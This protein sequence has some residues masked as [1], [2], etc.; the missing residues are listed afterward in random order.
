MSSTRLRRLL[1]V[2]FALLALLL[3]GGVGYGLSHTGSNIAASVPAAGQAAPDFAGI[4]DWENSPPLT[5][6]GLRGKVVLVDFWTY[7]CINCQRTFPYLRDWWHK[8]RDQGLVIVGVH[9]PEF[10]FEKNVPNIRAAIR[11]YGVEWPVAV[12]SA[13]T[14]WNAYQNQYWP[15][16]YLVDK[17]GNVR[18]R[19]EAAIRQRLADAGHP[20]DGVP[21]SRIDPGLTV[22]AQLQSHELY[23]AAGRGFSANPEHPGQA[24]AYTDPGADG[25][26]G[27]RRNNFIYWQG[28]WTIGQEFAEY[29]GASPPAPGYFAIE[30]QARNVYMVAASASGSRRAYVTLDGV[31]VARADAGAAIQYDGQGHSYV[32]VDRSDLF[33]LVKRAD[34]TRHVLRISPVDPGFRLFT[35]TFGS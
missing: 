13:M 31:D 2:A 12:D 20:V 26:D 15:A 9:S 18:Y 7:S 23:A 17:D 24:F 4:S 6:A 32:D 33:A 27:H 16:E 19:T 25:T 29:T 22:D 21:G 30:Y 10:E 28:T 1:P 34:F 14:T 5:L 11:E 8:Y 35:F 3:L